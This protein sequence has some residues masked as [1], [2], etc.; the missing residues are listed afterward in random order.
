MREP[1]SDLRGPTAPFPL[2]VL[3]RMLV[4][5][6]LAGGGL[7]AHGQSAVEPAKDAIPESALI[8]KPSGMLEEKIA[9]AQTGG[10]PVFL[11]GD[12]IS[13]RTDLE[14]VIEGDAAV[15]LLGES[16]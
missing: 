10:A 8:L 15:L 6:C 12:R 4:L 16:E 3:H 2:A 13:G 5:A 1:I 14:T 11:I 9:P 7:T